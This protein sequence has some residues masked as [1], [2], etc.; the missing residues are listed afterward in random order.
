[1]MDTIVLA[2][3]AVAV[4][5]IF[6]WNKVK[7]AKAEAALKVMQDGIKAQIAEL[8]QKLSQLTHGR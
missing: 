4:I 1:M 7:D 2:V 5:G 8:S 3:M 6:V